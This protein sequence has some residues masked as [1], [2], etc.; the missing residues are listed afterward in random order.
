MDS[1]SSNNTTFEMSSIEPITLFEV[2]NESV[3]ESDDESDNG[4]NNISA[5]DY[6]PNEDEGFFEYDDDASYIESEDDGDYDEE[7]DEE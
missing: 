2:S 7:Y 4:I 3:I 6:D 1:S 5:I